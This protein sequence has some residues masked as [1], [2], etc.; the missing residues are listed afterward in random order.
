MIDAVVGFMFSEDRS[1]VALIRKNRP[2]SQVG[3]LNGVG[4]KIEAGELPTSAMCREF[5]EETGFITC[6]DDWFHFITMLTPKWKL[7]YFK[8]VGNLD[9]LKSMTD[10]IVEIIEVKSLHLEN[11]MPNVKWMVPLCLDDRKYA[12]PFEITE[13]EK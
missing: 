6:Y 8:S 4:G 10:E 11:T 5:F 3:R 1:R 13:M 2:Q 7:W 9:V 12:F